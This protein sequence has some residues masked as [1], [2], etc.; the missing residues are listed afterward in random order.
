M[1]GSVDEHST[2]SDEEYDDLALLDGHGYYEDDVEMQNITQTNSLQSTKCD[3]S[4]K[5]ESF[6]EKYE[7][8]LDLA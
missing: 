4:S 6:I 7:R 3:F 1:E 5:V 8:N 2:K